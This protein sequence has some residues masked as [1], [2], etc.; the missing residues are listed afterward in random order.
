MSTGPTNMTWSKRVV[1]ATAIVYLLGTAS[2][3]FHAFAQQTTADSHVPGKPNAVSG[4]NPGSQAERSQYVIGEGDVLAIQ[5]WREVDLS[6]TVTVRPD[7]MISIALVGDVPAV[8][9]SPLELRKNLTR[10]YGTYLKA[11]EVSVIVQDARS[12]RF[13]VM[14]EVMKPG[15]YSL[16]K[17]MT[18]L[19]ALTIAG[20]FRDF[21]RKN[22]M[23]IIRTTSDGSRSQIRIDYRDVINARNQAGNPELRPRDTLVIP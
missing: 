13:G 18:V 3:P 4:L 20:G 6:R 12:L 15:T 23:F 21:A 19:D 7:G 10:L 11:P 5:V 9:M 2:L 22:K 17:G 8:G 1:S 16:T 14:G